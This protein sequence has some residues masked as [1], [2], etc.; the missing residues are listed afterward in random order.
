MDAPALV[1]YGLDTFSDVLSKVAPEFDADPVASFD[2]WDHVAPWVHEH[3]VDMGHPADIPFMRIHQQLPIEAYED[4]SF[5]RMCMLHHSGSTYMA[6]AIRT[7]REEDPRWAILHKIKS[8]AW[9]WG[10]CASGRI[11]WNDVVDLHA[12][13]PSFDIGVPGFEVTLDWTRSTNERGT[14]VCSR[15]WL[16]GVFAYLVHHRGRHVLTLGFSITADRRILIQQIQ[17]TSRRG[18]RWLF[19][20]PRNRVEHVVDRFVAAFPGFTVMLADGGDVAGFSLKGY[21]AELKQQSTHRREHAVCLRD[22]VGDPEHHARMRAYHAAQAKAAA[23]KV[24]HL[25]AELPRLDAFYADAGRYGRG[26][27]MTTNGLTHYAM[28]A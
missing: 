6:E 19:S 7:R 13:I 8:S 23:L 25:K 2:P 9:K 14:G 12:A 20:F 5:E 10:S 4:M 16:D 11:G 15:V 21:R 3:V 27:A 26:A 28:A 17:N 18:N 22:G 1:G 24:A